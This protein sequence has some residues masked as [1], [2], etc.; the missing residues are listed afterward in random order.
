MQPCAGRQSCNAKRPNGVMRQLQSVDTTRSGI[1]HETAL[2][3][4]RSLALLR[5]GEARYRPDGYF[6]SSAVVCSAP[7]RS[8]AGAWGGS[9]TSGTAADGP[10]SLP[11]STGYSL[12]HEDS[13][14]GPSDLV[15][16]RAGLLRQ[17][18]AGP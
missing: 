15:V 8:T 4:L 12:V 3:W 11:A 17:R 18:E 10:G 16:A 14:V 5:W 1:D 2:L 9:T 13:F 6:T 7:C